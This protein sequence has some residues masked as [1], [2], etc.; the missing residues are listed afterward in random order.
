MA[1]QTVTFPILPVVKTHLIINSVL[2][3]AAVVIV[4]FRVFARI[5]TGAK[6]W[7][8][9]YLI[10]LSM[11]L[12]IGMLV[13]QGLCRL[14]PR[15]FGWARR[16]LTDISRCPDGS[17]TPD[18]RDAA[19]S[20]HHLEADHC[21]CV[22]IHIMHYHYQT[23]HPLF[24]SPSLSQ[25]QVANRYPDCDRYCLVM[26]L[27]Q[28]PHVLLR[29]SAFRS[30]LESPCRGHLRRPNRDIP[31]SRSLQ[32]HK[33]HHHPHIAFTHNMDVKHEEPNEGCVDNTLLDR[34]AVSAFALLE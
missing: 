1:L 5:V 31:R 6:L 13:I 19:K 4:G 15:P 12:G 2:V 22:V 23:Q 30:D 32:H 8:D 20:S 34:L 27:G 14:H 9:D 11:P 16:L 21:I 25:Q 7:W 10:L 33:R 26:G 28:C 3:G 29:L 17:W 18:F 24:L